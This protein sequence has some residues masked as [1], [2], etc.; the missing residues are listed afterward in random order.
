MEEGEYFDPMEDLN[1]AARRRVLA[2]KEVQKQYDT[3][4]REYL[5]ELA[6]LQH[7]FNQKYGEYGK[8]GGVG[9]PSGKW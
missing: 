3:L 5:A 1:V 2:M 4:Q 6:V 9:A 7:K 8:A